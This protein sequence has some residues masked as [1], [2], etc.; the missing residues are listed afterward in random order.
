[1]VKIINLK[2]V[3]AKTNHKRTTTAS[4]YYS[5][6]IVKPICC[7]PIKVE[8]TSFSTISVGFRI[9]CFNLALVDAM[10]KRIAYMQ[11]H[12]RLSLIPRDHQLF[13]SRY[14]TYVIRL[15]KEMSEEDCKAT[16]R[17]IL[18][19][20]SE[21][22][23]TNE[24]SVWGKETEVE[25]LIHPRNFVWTDEVTITKTTAKLLRKAGISNGTDLVRTTREEICQIP[26]MT[27]K[28][29]YK[30]EKSLAS[31]GLF[32]RTAEPDAWQK[33]EELLLAEA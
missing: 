3:K 28:E 13:E 10:M 14:K 5:K 32:L 33:S 2:A 25:D 22:T 17:Q 21:E 9:D 29:V 18:I 31:R 11:N 26:G 1:M 27:T 12:W 8:R 24:I 6:K 7:S 15:L 23:Y 4:G 20:I 16:F 30:L 19:Q